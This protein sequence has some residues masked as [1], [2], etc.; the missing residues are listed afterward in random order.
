MTTTSKSS[1]YHIFMLKCWPEHQQNNGITTH[2]R[3]SIEDPTSGQRQGFGQLDD[4]LISVR[5][6]LQNIMAHNE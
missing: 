6:L 2:W 4:L 3:F 5:D 1:S